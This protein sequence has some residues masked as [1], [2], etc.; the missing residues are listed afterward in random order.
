MLLVN[1]YPQ[2]HPSRA[3]ELRAVV[4]AKR[5]TPVSAVGRDAG[6][7]PELGNSRTVELTSRDCEGTTTA[8]NR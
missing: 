7:R 2:F 6:K 1:E 5:K 3:G 8:E 4:E